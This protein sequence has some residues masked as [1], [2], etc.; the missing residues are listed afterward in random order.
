MNKIYFFLLATFF[1]IQA[2]ASNYP[3]VLF[4]NSLMPKS[5]YYS[6]SSFEGNS[7]I[8]HMNGHLPVAD[9]IFFSPGNSLL[10]D[11]VSG[12][13]GEWRSVVH[14]SNDYGYLPKSN[15]LL[16]FKIFVSSATSKS[17]LPIIQLMQGENLSDEVKL[18]AFIGNYQD[19]VWLS[20]A[21]PL[22]E[23][24]NLDSQ[25]P[26]NGIVFKQGA[27]RDGKEHRLFLDQI[28]FL[29]SKTPDMKLTGKAVLSVV[30]AYERHVDI[31]WQLPLTP[32]IRYIKIY[33][34]EDN[35]N[36]V[37]VAVR[38]IS[39]N[40]YTDFV[41]R[42]NVKYYYKIAWVDYQYRESPFSD[43]K[44]AETKSATDD[45]LLNVIEKSHIAYFTD[46]TEFNSGM[47]KISPLASNAHV[48][49]KGT[50]VGLLAQVV[51]VERK[52]IPRQLLLDRLKKIVKF[53]ERAT[54][55]HGAFPELLDGRSGKPIMTDS[56]EIAADLESTAY[57]MQGLLVARNYF[58][59]EEADE[60]AIREAITSLWEVVDWTKFVKDESGHHLYNTWSPVCAFAKA[61]PLGGY[62]SGF[63]A[64]LLAISSP[65]HAVDVNMYE[66]GLK[67]PLKHIGP[68]IGRLST[69]AN[70][71]LIM[72]KDKPELYGR[73]TFMTDST[74]YGI[75]LKAGSAKSSLI[76]Q[77]Q[78]FLAF[79]P[80][81]SIDGSVNYFDNQRALSTI[82]YRAA[83][84]R[85]EQFVSLTNLLWPYV[86]NDSLSVNRFNP[87]A[88]IAT[89]PYTPTIAMEA[90]KNY[91]RNLG[92]FLWTEYGFRD[93]F[94][95]KDNW[96]SS[97]FDPIHQGIVPIMLENARTGL[98]WNLF[99]EDPDI[100]KLAQKLNRNE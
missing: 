79:N 98:I 10:L 83:L 50:G 27:D 71:T 19:N 76:D 78:P 15:D 26:I 18:Q 11:Y 54:S 62:N 94:N 81:S 32:S 40:K 47:H 31:A 56:C 51:G 33:R 34:S 20:L 42:T 72:L 55:Y 87:S 38:P 80:K 25:A 95:F 8:N 60:K 96:V 82:Y 52:F 2:A 68:A 97:D 7:W 91:Y 69:S 86:G 53:L 75:Q 65:S 99:S 6:Q 90:L 73:D 41:P 16:H 9:S 63:I 4:E 45:E 66:L 39:F 3:E 21:I 28:E 17:E 14:Y 44:A 5:Y 12:N 92:S 37:P 67:Q 89:Y 24:G 48:S 88:A 64:Y 43:V 70:D 49:V 30:E 61:V 93:E 77:Q 46:E 35:Q 36:F 59:K 1:S 58:N 85:S 23:I 13:A 29:P 84:N 57:L 74:Y 22:K 100:K